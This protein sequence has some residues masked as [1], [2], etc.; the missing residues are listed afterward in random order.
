MTIIDMLREQQKELEAKKAV[1]D[2][3]LEHV[4]K[5]LA[6]IE[7]SGAGGFANAGRV[8]EENAKYQHPMPVDDAIVIAVKNG[9]KS[10]TEIHA[11]LRRKLGLHTTVGSI[12]TRVSKLRKK[13]RITHSAEGWLPGIDIKS[14]L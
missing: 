9:A 10:P 3:E 11:Y 5:A 4:Q 2:R 8:A 14:L 12:R 1:I 13:G 7:D 6:A